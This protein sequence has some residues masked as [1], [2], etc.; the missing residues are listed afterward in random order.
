M[1]TVAFYDPKN[2]LRIWTVFEG[3]KDVQAR[4]CA[5]LS[6]ITKDGVV[7][8]DQL[9]ETDAIEDLRAQ[10]EQEGLVHLD[11]DPTDDPVIVE[12]WL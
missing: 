8:T 10:F 2:T 1:G 6:L 9:I 3:A 12:V 5:R 7:A 11:R 4:Y